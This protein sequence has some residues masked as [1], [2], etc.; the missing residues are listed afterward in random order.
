[1]NDISK[2]GLKY[3]DLDKIK[4]IFKQHL[5]IDMV[6]IYGSRAKGNY[7]TY[8]DIDITL[9]GAVINLTS[10]NKIE[11]EL[12]DLLLPY[13]FDVSNFHKIENLDLIEHIKR[14]G[15]VIYTKSSP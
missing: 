11:N 4:L 5:E 9:I 7:S 3:S 12:D 6:I 8:S 15:K 10:Q 2:L 13:K 1:M 14:V